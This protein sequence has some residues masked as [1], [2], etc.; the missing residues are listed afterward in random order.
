MGS[1]QE[2]IT[3]TKKGSITSLWAIYV[4]TVPAPTT[5]SAHLDATTVLSRSVSERGTYPAMDPMD[6][7]SRIMD[8]NLIGTD[9][10]VPGLGKTVL[11]MELMNNVAKAY[12][13][14]SVF[15]SVGERTREGND[16]CNDTAYV[17][18][19]SGGIE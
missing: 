11:I 10:M 14:Y 16:A 7:F 2:R 6:S 17:E 4:W 18:N 12:G 13:G 3:I 5:T 9:Q 19:K 15:A 8:P 1:M